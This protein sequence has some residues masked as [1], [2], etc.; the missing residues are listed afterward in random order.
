MLS[1]TCNISVWPNIGV[2]CHIVLYL[3]EFIQQH[4]G[5]IVGSIIIGGLL[6]KMEGTY[7]QPYGERNRQGGG[8]D[9][10]MLV[11]E[12]LTIFMGGGLFWPPFSYIVSHF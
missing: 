2:F 7:L 4:L 10:E 6:Q 3:V 11:Q 1:S 8:C 9:R 12:F 5:Y